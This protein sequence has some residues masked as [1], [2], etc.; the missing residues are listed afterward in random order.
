MP[1]ARQPQLQLS[2]SVKYLLSC[3]FQTGNGSPVYSVRQRE[4][5]YSIF[6]NDLGAGVRTVAE[7]IDS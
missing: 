4:G 1:E 6:D 7:F 5:I 2:N 3:L